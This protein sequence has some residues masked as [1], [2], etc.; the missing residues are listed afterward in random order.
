[1]MRTR[2]A[3]QPVPISIIETNPN[4]FVVTR[5]ID[6]KKIIGSGYSEAFSGSRA[7]SGAESG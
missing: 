7:L 1:M 2:R 3:I 6:G 5:I 4:V